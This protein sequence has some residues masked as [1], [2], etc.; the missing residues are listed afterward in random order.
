MV[1]VL[2]LVCVCV[3]VI[4]ERG[5]VRI[6]LICFAIRIASSEMKVFH[7]NIYKW[8]EEKQH[9]FFLSIDNKI[10]RKHP[11]CRLCILQNEVYFW[12]QFNFLYVP[13]LIPLDFI[14]NFTHKDMYQF[15]FIFFLN[16]IFLNLF[17]GQH[18]YATAKING[19][20]IIR[21]YTPVSS[22]DDEGFVDLV[23]KVRKIQWK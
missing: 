15:Y 10:K 3:C 22:D 7:K 13:F 5:R 11:P 12:C 2:I 8:Q 14:S 9:F 21:P 17:L 20:L 19:Q 1:I 18:I 4:Y 16:L 6:K 23:V